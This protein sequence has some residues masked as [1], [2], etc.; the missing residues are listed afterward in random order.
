MEQGEG[1]AIHANL[2][3]PFPPIPVIAIGQPTPDQH[4][5]ENTITVSGS[6]HLED[7]E[8]TQSDFT[9]S[10]AILSL[11]G[12]DQQI[13]VVNG[14]FGL[15]I[16]IST[17]ENVLQVRANGPNGDTGVSP[18]VHFWGDFTIHDIRVTLTWNTPTA[19]LDLHVWN[20]L[21]EHS[22]YGHKQISDGVLDLDDTEGYGPENFT[23][24]T[25]TPGTYT[26]SVNSYSLDHDA[27]SDATVAVTLG[28]DDPVIYGPFRFTVADAN[29]SGGINPAAWWEVVNI[30]IGAGGAQVTVGPRTFSPGLIDRVRKDSGREPKRGGGG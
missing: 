25:A 5:W 13:Q 26:V 7:Q 18:E 4:F 23:S 19:D 21:G 24:T 29:G 30:E 17:G 16:P 3:E 27:Y 1:H 22:Y 11:N 20:P 15:T 12:G 9:G 10:H 6:I 28:T 14:A 8:G 2:G